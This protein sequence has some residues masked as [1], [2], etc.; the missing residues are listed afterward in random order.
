MSVYLHLFH[1]RNTP[2]EDLED[3]GFDGGI[4]GPFQYL[5]MTYC[6][7][8]KFSMEEAAYRKAFPEDTNPYVC[9]GQVEGHLETTEGLIVYQGKYYGDLSICTRDILIQDF[10]ESFKK[11]EA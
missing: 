4:L 11:L 5:H 10:P 9:E 1:G 8:L 6:S 2:D 7:D 3:W